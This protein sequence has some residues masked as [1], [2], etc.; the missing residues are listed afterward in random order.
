MTKT[1]Y[2]NRNNPAKETFGIIEKSRALPVSYK[3][4]PAYKM[5]A[6]K[7]CRTLTKRRI[8]CQKIFRAPAAAKS[9]LNHHRPSK[10]MM[11]IDGP[12]AILGLR[13]HESRAAHGGGAG[14]NPGRQNNTARNLTL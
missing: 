11:I 7:I 5:P 2:N 12:P 4:R 6:F 3:E 14:E 13:H 8:N 10:P 1:N 9:L